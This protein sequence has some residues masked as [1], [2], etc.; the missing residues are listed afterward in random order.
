MPNEVL[1]KVGTQIRFCVSGDLNIVDQGT[2]WTIGSPTNVALTLSALAD[3]AGRQSAKVNLGTT[4]A[5]A[6]EVLGC[7][8]YTGETPVQ[9]QTVDYYWA[10]STSTTTGTG[11]VAGN[12][13]SDAACPGG[14]LGGIT[15]TEFLKQCL[16]IGSLVLHDGGVVQNGFVGVFSPPGQYGQLIVVNNGGDAFEADNAEHHQVFNPIVDEVQD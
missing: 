3:A 1:Q 15:L 10:P 14:A 7:V 16:Y 4:R 11:N 9:F 12:S 13:G 2:N 8:D 6:Y 5:R